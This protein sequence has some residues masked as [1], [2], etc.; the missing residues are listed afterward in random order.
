LTTRRRACLQKII[1]KQIRRQRR[2]VLPLMHRRLTRRQRKLR[3][4]TVFSSCQKVSVFKAVFQGKSLKKPATLQRGSDSWTLAAQICCVSVPCRSPL[5]TSFACFSKKRFEKLPYLSSKIGYQ[6][7]FKDH[8][9]SF[10]KMP[11]FY[12]FSQV[13]MLISSEETVKV[14]IDHKTL[15][16]SSSL[17]VINER[18]LDY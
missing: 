11:L 2:L 17:R 15:V 10:S 7:G 3:W 18:L 6:Q 9:N 13:I 8:K 1:C 16:S 14:K 12:S 4:E 5:D